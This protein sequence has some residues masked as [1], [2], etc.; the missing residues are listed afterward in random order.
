MISA[1]LEKHA[2]CGRFDTVDGFIAI[3]GDCLP[4][5]LS[6]RIKAEWNETMV[7]RRRI[8]R[9]VGVGDPNGGQ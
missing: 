9:S 7:T 3:D 4:K 8:N 5:Q 2:L 1:T 6:R